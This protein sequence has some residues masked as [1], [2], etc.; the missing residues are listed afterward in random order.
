M[1]KK[2]E[3]KLTKEE[4]LKD[5]ESKYG[6]NKPALG[7][8]MVVD[9]GSIQ[10]NEAT[11]I[12]GIPVGKLIE[13][14]GKESSGKST[15]TLHIIREFQKAF[16]EKSVALIDYENSFDNKYARNIGV[17]TDSLLIYQPN[18]LEN[19]Y[20]MIL[21]LI[22]KELVSL[23]VLDSHTAAIP[24]AII[25]GEMGDAT[26]G[27]QARLNSK[28]CGKLK[29]LLTRHNCTLL[30]VSQLRSNI[31]GFGPSAGGDVSTGGQAWRF[32]SD[33]R[34]KVWK[35]NDKEGE[36]NKTTV[37]IVKNKMSNPFG[38]AKFRILW[39]IGIDNVGEIID[40]SVDF[41]FIKKSASWYVFGENKY[42]GEENMRDFL[43]ENADIYSQLKEQV[44]NRLQE[45]KLKKK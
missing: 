39:G 14:E 31:G 25:E 6:M 10:I 29:N 5:L 36:A 9:S 18:S 33:M 15:L 22:E 1:A 45:K 7:D 32:Y 12:G 44:L 13:L 37:D 35:M 38:Q 4:I 17:D 20:D 11:G 30:A 2:K 16:P 23:V 19:G 24:K 34:W 42:Q 8:L 3:E 40:Y 28:F 26:M 21:S 27:L 43:I 41:G